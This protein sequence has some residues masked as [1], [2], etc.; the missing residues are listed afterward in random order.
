MN[1]LSGQSIGRY[2]IIEPLGEGGMAVVYK[3]YDTRLECDVAVKFIRTDQLAPAVLERTLK[4]FERE[5]KSVAQLTHPNIVK[6][7]DYGDHEGVPYLVMAYYPEGTLKERMS[8]PVGYGEAA[9]LLVPIA[10]GLEYAHGRNVVHRDVKP[11]NILMTESGEPM[12]TDFGI[13]K[14][15]DLKDGQT[16]TAAGMGV[17]TPEYM[18]P[19]QGMGSDVDGRADIYALGV[20]FYELI[21]GR[22]PYKANTPM[23]VLLQSI[24]DPL[25]RPSEFVKGIPKQVEQVLYKALAKDPKDRY[26]NMREFVRVLE[27]LGKNANEAAF[28]GAGIT[29]MKVASEP[30]FKTTDTGEAVQSQQEKIEDSPKKEKKSRKNRNIWIWV[31]LGLITF[32]VI[33]SLAGIFYFKPTTNIIKPIANIIPFNAAYEEI[34]FVSYREGGSQLFTMNPDGRNQKQISQGKN[35]HLY[36]S[37]SPDRS[38]IAYSNEADIYVM[39]ADG[40]DDQKTFQNSKW[41]SHPSWSPDG[42]KIAYSTLVGGKRQ[43]YSIGFGD[44]EPRPNRLSYGDVN[45]SEP[46][47]SPNGMK[48][49]FTS[50]INTTNEIYIMNSDG[51]YRLRLTSNDFDDTEPAWSPDGKKIAFSTN[52]DGNWEVY[53]LNVESGDVVNLT[54]NKSSDK[55]PTWSPDGIKIAFTSDRDGNREIYVMNADGSEQKNLTNNIS[56]DSQPAWAS[57]PLSVNQTGNLSI[58]TP[59]APS[60]EISMPKTTVANEDIPNGPIFLS[61]LVPFSSTVGRGVLGVGKMPY[62]S[63]EDN[64]FAG[65]PLMDWGFTST[66]Y[67]N[68]LFA[69]APSRI[70]YRLDGNYS[71]LVSSFFI[72][73]GCGSVDGVIFRVLADGVEKFNS[74]IVKSYKVPEEIQINNPKIL[75]LITDPVINDLCDWSVW[76]NPYLIK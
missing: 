33:A 35:D 57:A 47:W 59:A 18:A 4:R 49:A 9:K 10:R 52:R 13:A 51:T 69:Q 30:D 22:T 11:S 62:D 37:W 60:T 74:G 61:N 48:I 38:K 12:L 53:V 56:N 72:N 25:P 46:A 31:G 66:S 2:H 43:I 5:A 17:G 24:N 20:V 27:D 26:Q 36:P 40:T 7:T 45:D 67:D 8:G 75:T 54:G 34:V 16:L 39:D 50:K 6:V 70:D 14:I 58:S 19:E 42:K 23:A 15:L 28:A 44:F 29:R 71:K 55:E 64:V 65:S 3:A 21:T 1:D 32:A 68:G 76:G 41:D 63:P 73:K